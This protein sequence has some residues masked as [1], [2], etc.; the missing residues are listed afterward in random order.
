MRRIFDDK[1]IAWKN[2]AN[3][4][5][6]IVRGARQVGKTWSIDR[7]GAREFEETV[8]VDFEK[9]PSLIPL[10]KADLSPT[11]LLEQLEVTVGKK[12]QPG[13]TIY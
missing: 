2:S 4:K 10:F 11:R 13:R 1:L 6:L 7:F 12:I 8:K 9:R 3:R 5:P